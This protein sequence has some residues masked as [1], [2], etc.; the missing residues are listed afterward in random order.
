[1]FY[2][3]LGCIGLFGIVLILAL[4]LPVVITASVTG[5]TAKRFSGSGSVCL[6]G[7]LLGIEARFDKALAVLSLRVGNARIGR[8]NVKPS[9]ESKLKKKKTKQPKET[10][11]PGTEKPL[12]ERLTEGWRTFREIAPKLKKGYHDFWYVIAI[13]RFSAHVGFGLE[14]PARMGKLIGVIAFING[15]L[16]KPCSIRQS[17]DFTR[18][19]AEGDLDCRIRIRLDR[20]WRVAFT[21]IPDILRLVRDRRKKPVEAQIIAQEVA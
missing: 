19:Y 11:V 12:R 18:R 7:G 21:Y 5:G 13:Q 3:V 4:V 8:Y 6:F 10:P 1:M 2:W 14:N 17:F 16:P 20:F 15:L 9:G